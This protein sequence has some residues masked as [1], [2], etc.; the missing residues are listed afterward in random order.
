[1]NPDKIIALLTLMRMPNLGN[2]SIKKL[3]QIVGSPEGVLVEK[4]S[5]LLKIHGIGSKRIEGLYSSQYQKEAEQ[6]LRF[7]TEN[8]IQYTAYDE[9]EYPERLR[10]CID[11][12]LVLFSKGKIALQDKKILSIVGTRKVT[13]YGMEFCEA[14]ISA[15]APINPVIVSGLA[16]GVDIVAH[17]SAMEQGLQTVACLA[18]GLNQIYPKVHQKYRKPIE[19]NGGFFTEYW[20]TDAFDRKNFLG[21]NRIIA[22]LSEATIVIESAAKGGS[23]VTAALAN[24]YHREVFAVPGRAGDVLSEGC[25]TLIKTQQAHILTHAADIMYMLNWNIEEQPKPSIQKQLF[26]ELTQQEEPIYQFLN[27]N[28]KQLLDSIALHCKLPTHKIAASLLT[29]EL[30]GVIRPLPGNLFEAI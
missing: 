3:I 30:K 5:N 21:R 9:P 28:G 22:G 11:G 4:P 6:E 27:D 20:S 26:V 7:I 24:S 14:L 12:P 2:G 15:L 19:A 17:R 8:N 29:M 13:S 23:L 16:Y 18:H 10:H 25:N 1:M